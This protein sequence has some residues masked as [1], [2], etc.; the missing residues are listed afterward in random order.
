MIIWEDF[1]R[2][3]V[4]DDR[5]GETKT[6]KAYTY[7]DA[8]NCLTETENGQTTVN[9]YNLLNQLVTG[10]DTSYSYDANGNLT[11]ESGADLVK[12]YTYDADNRLDTAVFTE[13]GQTK[14]QQ[15]RTPITEKDSGYPRP[16]TVLP[17][18]TAI[19]AA[20]W[21]I[22]TAVRIIGLSNIMGDAGNVIASEREDGAYFYNK[23][24]RSSTTTVTDGSGNCKASIRI[25]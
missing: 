22:Q 8:G 20:A 3:T 12:Q 10:G 4:I 19:R 18:T 1:C 21:S 17:Q 23:D 15:S 7:D 2:T 16:K 6:Q 5:T 25:H 11:E 13:K 24:M 14:V 9:T